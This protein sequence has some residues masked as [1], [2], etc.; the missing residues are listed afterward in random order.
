MISRQRDRIVNVGT[1]RAARKGPRFVVDSIGPGVEH[2][3]A[4]ASRHLLRGKS[5]DHRH[6]STDVGP[7]RGSNLR[8]DRALIAM[9]N[10]E[11]F[12]AR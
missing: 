7:E 10:G 6:A 3:S 8:Y 1:G 4:A 11:L 9:G 12:S 2:L 5:L